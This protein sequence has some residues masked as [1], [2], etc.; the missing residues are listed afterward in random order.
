MNFIKRAVLYTARK[1]QQSLIAFLILLAVCTSALM[2]LSILKATDTAAANLRGQFGG[3]FS[4]R[5]DMSNPANMNSVGSTDRYSGSYYSGDT[6]DNEVIDEVL[7][8]PGIADY[9]ANVEV[10]ANLKSED[11]QYYNLAENKIGRAHV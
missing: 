1:W 2:G 4:L 11:G 7:K 3:T 9:S 10:A 6:I 8:T 5:I